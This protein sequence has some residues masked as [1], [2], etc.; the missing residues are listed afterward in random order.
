MQPSSVRQ[1]PVTDTETTEEHPE[2]PTIYKANRLTANEQDTEDQPRDVFGPLLAPQ[3]QPYAASSRGALLAHSTPPLFTPGHNTH[4]EVYQA[5]AAFL[6]KRSRPG[7]Y[8]VQLPGPYMRQA[9][10]FLNESSQPF[11][12]VC[13]CLGQGRKPVTRK[14]FAGMDTQQNRVA[15][16]KHT[17][18]RS[19]RTIPST[20][21]SVRAI[22]ARHSSIVASPLGAGAFK[23]PSGEAT[24]E[25]CPGQEN[26]HCADGNALLES[27]VARDIS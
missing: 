14:H 13:L 8:V 17:Q 27:F 4:Q 26:A 18:L 24:M 11:P 10:F 25:E 1:S 16:L 2:A 9:A 20:P 23:A 22:T 5:I 19:Q 15:V 3:L 21:R 6:R 12:R 7:E